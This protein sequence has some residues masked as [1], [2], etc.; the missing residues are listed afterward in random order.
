MSGSYISNLVHFVWSTSNRR[1]WIG[2][3][4]QDRLYGYIGGILRNK[5]GK[6]LRCGGRSDHVHMYAS[7]PSTVSVAKI[8]EAVKSNSSRWIHE[9]IPGRQ[10]FK[11]QE[12]YGAFTVSKSCEDRLIKYIDNQ[13]QHHRKRDFKSEFVALLVQH[14]V[15]YD[16]KYI[17]D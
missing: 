15:A 7:L 16:A 9:T 1:A 3:S 13:A 12:G 2:E 4:W 14:A 6:L 17:W 5:N 11:W 10:D 8:A